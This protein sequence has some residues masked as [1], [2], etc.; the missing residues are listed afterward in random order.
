[1]MSQEKSL[2]LFEQAQNYMPGP[3]SNLRAPARVKPLFIDHGHGARL[4]DVDGNEYIDFVCGYGPGILGHGNQEY[5]KALKDQL[6]SL[7]YLSTGDFRTAIEVDLAEK[8]V[9][10]VPCA[11]QVRFCLAGTEAVQ[12]AIRMA[13]A[14][15]NRPRF[16]RFEG[17]Y[18]GWLDNVL[19]GSVDPSPAG[20]PFALRP[21]GDPMGSEGV[22]PGSVEES[23]KLP[24]NDADALA[25]VLE[26]YGDEVA[27]VLMEPILLNYGCCPP[28]AGY[29]EK[30]RD[31][32]T[33]HG[34]VLC[35]DEVQTGFR[36]GLNSAQ[37]LFGVT[38]DL[39]TFGKSFAGGIPLGAVAGKR[40]IMDLLY[41]RRVLGAGTFNGYPFG[42][43]AALANLTILERDN[44]AIY[45]KINDVQ[46]RLMD[47]LKQI[48]ENCGLP[49]LIQGPTGVFAFLAVDQEVA[50]SPRDL[51]GIDWKTQSRF[52]KQMAEEG[53]LLVR[54]GRWF[55]SAAV[56]EKDV[57]KALASAERVMKNLSN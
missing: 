32:C 11:E 31:L 33:R 28:R 53:V 23:F 10:C 48:A 14:Y 27:M 15:T 21:T 41:E 46:K 8:F 22:Y 17:H 39:S 18:H 30:V 25:R 51:H 55:V 3:H 34:V 49:V 12:L 1:M 16:I 24:W 50:Y 19:G 35:L 37:G 2:K 6:D 7:I 42:L 36:V 38:P 13:R 9:R 57:E 54:G 52:E 29:L 20:R 26:T 44:G 47:G 45:R 56:S 43:A 5:I 40:A 4:W